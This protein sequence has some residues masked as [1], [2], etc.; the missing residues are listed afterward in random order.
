MS[1]SPEHAEFRDQVQRAYGTEAKESSL[2]GPASR[3]QPGTMAQRPRWP[4]SGSSAPVLGFGSLFPAVEGASFSERRGLWINIHADPHN[5]GEGGI[6]IDVDEVFVRLYDMAILAADYGHALTILLSA[7][8][9][10]HLLS[11]DTDRAL[12]AELLRDHGHKVGFHHHDVSHTGGDGWDGYH[13]LELADCLDYHRLLE[14]LVARPV[15]EA[16]SEYQ[17]LAAV[18]TTS[19]G[20]PGSLFSGRAV[21]SHGTEAAYREQ[22]WQDGVLYS[23]G[24]PVPLEMD[25]ATLL[26]TYSDTVG[27]ETYNGV[28]VAETGGTHFSVGLGFDRST[29]PNT[30][31]VLDSLSVAGPGDYVG[32]TIHAWEFRPETSAPGGSS[33]FGIGEP[34]KNDDDLIRELFSELDR[35]GFHAEP[36]GVIMDRETAAI[37]LPCGSLVVP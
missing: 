34:R 21:A 5:G 11:D 25:P 23:H 10:E 2:M 6:P 7:P 3:A 4:G 19:H 32:V 14:C 24:P 16:Y 13:S 29:D 28:T 8:W 35:Q 15:E 20:V 27:C 9:T 36:M 26:R 17:T 31:E 22:E 1:L 12:F 37:G 33:S 30:N 18:L